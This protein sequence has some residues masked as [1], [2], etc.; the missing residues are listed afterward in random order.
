MAEIKADPNPIIVDREAGETSGTTKITYSKEAL[1]E[2]WERTNSGSWLEIN[3]HV[4][5]GIGDE[6]DFHGV[7]EI[8]LKPGGIYEVCVFRNGQG[9]LSTDPVLVTTI[10]VFCLLKKPEV[11]KLITDIDRG[12][13]G[14]WHI[15]RMATNVPTDIVMIGVMREKPKIDSNG[16]PRLKDPDGVPTA[17]LTTTDNHRVEIKPLFPGNH[18]FFVVVVV[19]IFGNWEVNLEEFTTLRRKITV[20]FPT[21]HIFNDGDPRG[22][23]AG[24]FWF[25]VYKGSSTQ[26]EV[27][28]E[29][30]LPTQDIDDW[31]ETD[32]PYS[33]GFAHVG[34]LEVV[35]P[36]KQDVR[37]ASWGIEHDGVLE[38]DEYAS[39]FG[40]LLPIPAGLFVETVINSFFKMDC[41]TSS[42]GD[43]FHYG[44]DVRWSV[45]YG[46]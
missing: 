35:E 13:G 45:E 4:R 38:E 18:Y 8:T 23:G 41:P 32:R 40:V 44:V 7:Y 16:I 5:T 46:A 21:I 2:L 3:V 29:F 20:E 24:E 43:D 27:I 11:R 34:V 33:V 22:V 6:A 26:Q 31:N 1:E 9:P 39:N 10:K 36:G 42:A 25:G 17:P 37:V 30:H 15:H 14:T 28:Q 12:S 19:D